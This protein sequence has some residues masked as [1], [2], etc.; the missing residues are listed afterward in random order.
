MSDST[1]SYKESL[2][3]PEPTQQG[4]E[5]PVLE[6]QFEY[7]LDVQERE[8]E[9]PEELHQP[10]FLQLVEFAAQQGLSIP[11][12]PPLIQPAAI[13]AAPAAAVNTGWFQDPTPGVFNGDC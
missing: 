2:E 12:P 1:L 3:G 4:Q 5:D 7:V 8:P 9:N 11:V 6:A 13:M 10:A